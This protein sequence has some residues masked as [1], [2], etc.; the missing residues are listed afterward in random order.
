M[1]IFSTENAVAVPAGTTHNLWNRPTPEI[2]VGVNDTYDQ[3]KTFSSHTHGKC[4]QVYVAVY[5]QTHAHTSAQYF[6]IPYGHS[7]A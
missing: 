3:S 2:S 7:H 4:M 6:R 5:W 1:S